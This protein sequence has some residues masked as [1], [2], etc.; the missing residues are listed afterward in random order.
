MIEMTHRR[1]TSLRNARIDRILHE[2]KFIVK[3]THHQPLESNLVDGAAIVN[4][5]ERPEVSGSYGQPLEKRY[6]GSVQ[7]A[8]ACSLG[9]CGE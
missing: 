7:T 2:F 3:V 8:Y 5:S 6:D 1:N 9:I 4:R